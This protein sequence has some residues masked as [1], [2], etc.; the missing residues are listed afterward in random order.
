MVSFS[1]LFALR[2]EYRTLVDEL[3]MPPSKEAPLRIAVI[4]AGIG[5]LAFTAMVSREPGAQ[6]R[7][8]EQAKAFARVG[9]G[10]QQSPNSVKVLRGIG[11][12]GT[13]R[14]KA[15][16]PDASLNRQFDTG[17]TTWERRL[18]A[19][20]EALYGA[21]HLYMHR[22]DLHA[23]LLDSVPDGCIALGHKLEGLEVGASGVKLRFD[24]GVEAIADVVIGADG[25][26]SVVREKL[27]GPEAPRFTGRVAYR[28]TFSAER[29]D[30]PLLDGSCKW[31]GPDRHIVIYYVN[32]RRDEVYFVT[33]TPEPDF[34]QESWS[35]EGDLETLKVAYAEFHPAVKAVLEAC[36]RVHKW[37]L[38]D[39]DPM[40]RWHEGPIA[41]LGDA[42]HPMTP[43]MAQGAAQAIED[44][45]VL[46]RCLL[47]VDRAGV[48]DALLAYER[49]RLPRTSRIQRISRLNDMAAI[50][51][52]IAAVYGYDAWT[53]P[54]V[55]I[56]S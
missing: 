39:R 24:N 25:V 37:A 17:E 18:G 48:S 10:I 11:L 8:F 44:A 15:F 33:S 35:Q 22:G 38:F 34:T 50:K 36:P 14:Q 54:L 3:E 46:S 29:L 2:L 40:A 13:L 32:P 41:L 53:A 20:V 52:E 1:F 4:G 55:K 49:T 42:C 16:R 7:V 31:W 43:Y 6:V 30:E 56:G 26:H 51:A 27:F 28:T 9:A 21:P 5:G 45:A 12:E 23:A 47:K 19:E